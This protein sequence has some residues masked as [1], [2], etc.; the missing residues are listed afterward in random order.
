MHFNMKH[1]KACV[2]IALIFLAGFAVGAVT[3]RVA[4]RH[5]VLR[6]IRDPNVMRERVEHRIASRLRLDAAQRA[7]VH[8]IMIETQ[9]QL[10]GLRTEFQ[11][12]F[13]AIMEHSQSEIAAVLRPDQFR[14]FEQF[15]SENRGWWQAREW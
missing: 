9:G 11:P 8:E 5:F 10:K 15:Q 12:R 4:V 14:R 7:K 13:L 6:V 1:L 3:T 2:L